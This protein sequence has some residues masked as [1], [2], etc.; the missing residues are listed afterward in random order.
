MNVEYVRSGNWTALH[1]VKIPWTVIGKKNL[2]MGSGSLHRPVSGRQGAQGRGARSVKWVTMG[3][4]HC[5]GKWEYTLLSKSVWV[6][7]FFPPGMIQK[8]VYK[9]IGR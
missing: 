6:G 5:L 2:C 7:F 1:S 9:K 4:D 8:K 3:I